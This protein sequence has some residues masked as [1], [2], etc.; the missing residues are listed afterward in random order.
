MSHPAPEVP[1]GRLQR[2]KN[3]LCHFLSNPLYYVCIHTD[4]NNKNTKHLTKMQI[5]PNPNA[6]TPTFLLCGVPNGLGITGNHFVWKGPLKS[7]SPAISPALP[8]P[9]LCLSTLPLQY[10]LGIPFWAQHFSLWP[11]NTQ[12]ISSRLLFQGES[13]GTGTIFLRVCPGQWGPGLQIGFWQLVHI[14][15]NCNHNNISHNC[16]NMDFRHISAKY[17]L[18]FES[19]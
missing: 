10:F 18:T 12:F 15:N 14:K 8:S 13:F 4:D 16:S 1:K 11:I 6:N 19:V 9:C 7:S 3:K 2:Q 5:F 17:F